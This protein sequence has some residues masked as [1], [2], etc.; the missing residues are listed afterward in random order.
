MVGRLT[1]LSQG[2]SEAQRYDAV[3]VAGHDAGTLTVD[4]IG[5]NVEGGPE[6]SSA[7]VESGRRRRMSE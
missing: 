6:A 7:R 4:A 1:Q 5:E 2:F 3:V